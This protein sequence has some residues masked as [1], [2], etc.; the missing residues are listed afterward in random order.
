MA[1]S[2]RDRID[3]FLAEKRIAF[4]GVSRKEHDFSRALFRE[5]VNRGYDVAPVHPEADEIEG[6]KCAPHVQD[7]SPPVAA[8]LVMT[9]RAASEQVVA[10]CAEAGVRRVW[11]Y[12]GGPGGA[13][14]REAV[15][16]CNEKGIDVIPGY[17]P[18]MFFENA[19]LLHR[20]HGAVLK[21]FGRYPA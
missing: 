15:A 20:F 19:G 13:V 1:A 18:L 5:F 6:R 9:P 16:A 17:C 3:E 8:V 2:L 14:S 10:D 4:V 12:K 21:L 11:L 7:V